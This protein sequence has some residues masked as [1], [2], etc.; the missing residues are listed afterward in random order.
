MHKKKLINQIIFVHNLVSI[1]K[2]FV[3]PADR[4][5]N[6]NLEPRLPRPSFLKL[7]CIKSGH[8]AKPDTALLRLEVFQEFC[9]VHSSVSAGVNGRQY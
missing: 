4:D 2:D 1:I 9:F 8:F 6:V 5:V 3:K 7:K